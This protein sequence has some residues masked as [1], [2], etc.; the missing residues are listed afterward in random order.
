MRRAEREAQQRIERERAARVRARRARWRSL[1]PRPRARR[2]RRDRSLLAA[3]RRR[4]DGVLIAFLLAGHVALWIATDSWWWR[5]GLLLMTVMAWPLLV[6]VVFD[7]RG[8]R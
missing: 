7:R 8:S 1:A 3:Q 2:R 6:T 4:Q 5:I